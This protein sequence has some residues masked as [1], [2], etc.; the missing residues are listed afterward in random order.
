MTTQAISQASLICAGQSQRAASL[1]AGRADTPAVH[2]TEFQGGMLRHGRRELAKGE[3]LALPA[4]NAT[5]VCLDGELWLTRDGDA[6]D[7]ILGAGSSLH[8]KLNDQA[9]VVALK[10]SR[11]RLIPA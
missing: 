10:P 5:V 1:R 6:E 7:Y 9:V 8:V 3:L 4:I 2:G 11:L